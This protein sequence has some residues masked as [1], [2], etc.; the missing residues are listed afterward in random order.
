MQEEAGIISC[1]KKSKILGEL[2]LTQLFLSP[3]FLCLVIIVF[4]HLQG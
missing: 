4:V 3:T 2:L 1:F